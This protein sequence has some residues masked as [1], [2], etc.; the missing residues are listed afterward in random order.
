MEE[1]ENKSESMWL[2]ERKVLAALLE[3][4]YAD[5]FWLGEYLGSHAYTTAALQSLKRRG[6]AQG[7][8][9]TREDLA[10]KRVWTITS[11]GVQALAQ[12]RGMQKL[13]LARTH[14]YN[15]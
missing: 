13:V 8:Q 15:R 1:G 14:A 3:H 6:Y 2:G 10:L 4:P 11:E 7:F 5:P 9:F 12:L